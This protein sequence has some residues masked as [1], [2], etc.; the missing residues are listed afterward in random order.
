MDPFATDKQH[1][2]RAV[3][4]AIERTQLITEER[5]LLY[6]L[7]KTTRECSELIAQHEHEAESKSFN[8]SAYAAALAILNRK[9][10]DLGNT[11]RATIARIAV[12]RARQVALL[13][14]LSRASALE[15]N[16]VGV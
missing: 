14:E 2:A 6:V 8:G 16:S 12:N 13:T 4:N 15:T 5:Q 9:S 10:I 1:E 11:R 3:K 7:I